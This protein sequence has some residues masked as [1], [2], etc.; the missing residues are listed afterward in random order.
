MVSYSGKVNGVEA[1]EQ[2]LSKASVFRSFS[3][4]LADLDEDPE[5]WREVKDELNDMFG[6]VDMTLV[7]IT[8]FTLAYTA[9]SR[10]HGRRRSRRGARGQPG[11][12]RLRGGARGGA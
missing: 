4:M 5:M 2:V 3:V 10:S 1:D 9:R 7:L 8:A 11:R 12:E 6:K